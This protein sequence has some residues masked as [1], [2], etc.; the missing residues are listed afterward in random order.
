MKS[1]LERIREQLKVEHKV[2][3]SELS[4]KYKVTEETIRRDLEKLE[5]E[6]F[7]TRTFGGAVLNVAVQK[8]HI[9]FYKRA[10]INRE[11]KNKIA[12]LA[13]EILNKK[14]TISTDASTTVM[15]AVKL[16]KENRD[17]TVLSVSTEIFREL[18]GSEINIISA[19]GTFNQGT[20]SLQGNLAK[21]NI[22]RYHVDIALLSCNG[23]DMEKGITDSTER[24]ADVKAEMIKQAQA[25]MLLADHTK[26]EKTAFV[27][28]LDAE[29]MDYLVTDEDPGQEWKKFC[30]KKGIQLIY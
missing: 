19:G 4:K 14:R 30:E 22:K 18:A 9:H 17:L 13:A 24:E 20:L 2:T 21:E 7:L 23:I 3:V 12:G 25:V 11:A 27:K 10:S 8:E 28:F 1:R 29:D 26:F 15:E 16:L 6:G 5:A